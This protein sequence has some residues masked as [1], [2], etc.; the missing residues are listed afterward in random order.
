MAKQA[1]ITGEVWK[2]IKGYEGLYSVSNLGRVKRIEGVAGETNRRQPEKILEAVFGARGYYGVNLCKNGTQKSFYIHR[3]VALA[4][5]PNPNR[6]KQVNHKD[7]DVANNRADNL[8]WCD[9]KYNYYY[10][11]AIARR[12][13]SHNKAVLQLNAPQWAPGCK[14]NEIVCCYKNMEQ[15]AEKGYSPNAVKKCCQ[16]RQQSHAGFYWKY[17]ADYYKGGK[18]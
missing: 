8:E 6:L 3:L 16:G 13:L 2:P 15:V 9:A 4:F 7:E 10:G 5:V 17:S 12:G 1:K 14:G 11:T 18:E